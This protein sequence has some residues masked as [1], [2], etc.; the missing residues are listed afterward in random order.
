VIERPVTGVEHRDIEVVLF[1]PS[2][3]GR[4]V[5]GGCRDQRDGRTTADRQIP[6]PRRIGVPALAG[7]QHRPAHRALQTLTLRRLDSHRVVPSL[8]GGVWDAQ[9]EVVT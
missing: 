1:R 2:S 6:R 8:R 9:T 5:S 3:A 4:D 7:Q